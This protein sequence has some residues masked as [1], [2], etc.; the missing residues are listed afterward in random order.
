MSMFS[1]SN[2]ETKK[3]IIYKSGVRC[4][5]YKHMMIVVYILFQ[6]FL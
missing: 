1:N 5:V 6:I 3:V 4:A 2:T